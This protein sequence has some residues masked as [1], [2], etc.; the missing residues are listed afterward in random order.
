MSILFFFRVWL[1]VFC[2]FFFRSACLRVAVWKFFF[3]FYFCFWAV[4]VGRV[5]FGAVFPIVSALLFRFVVPGTCLVKS[6]FWSGP[7][8]A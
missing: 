3:F 5:Y 2:R 7:L 6:F 1:G 4:G 8:F